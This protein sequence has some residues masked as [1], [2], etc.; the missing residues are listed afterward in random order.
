[1]L[2]EE[3][4]KKKVQ[5]LTLG[6]AR[7][8][9]LACLWEWYIGLQYNCNVTKQ[10]L[11]KHRNLSTG[12]QIIIITCSRLRP[13]HGCKARIISTAC[14]HTIVNTH[15]HSHTH[16]YTMNKLTREIITNFN[17]PLFLYIEKFKLYN[18]KCVMKKNHIENIKKYCEKCKIPYT[19]KTEA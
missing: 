17:I 2:H 5:E 19:F 10:K 7:N 3:G 9:S 16:K 12:H 4:E 6:L 18:V 15:I 11:H 1:M 14:I 8:I 13:T